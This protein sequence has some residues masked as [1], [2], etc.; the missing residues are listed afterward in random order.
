MKIENSFR[1]LIEVKK[2]EDSRRISLS[3]RI[4]VIHQAEFMP[5]LGFISK[6][7]MG[8]LYFVFDTA[9]FSKE[10][11]ENRNKIRIANGIGWQWLIIPAKGNKSHILNLQDV[12]IA[13]SKWKMKHLKSIQYSYQRAPFF[14]DYFPELESI[15][16]NYAGTSLADYNFELIKFA[17]RKFKINI[18]VY[19]TS[20][21]IRNGYEI[22][23]KATELVISMCKVAGADVCVAGAQG[24][25]YLIRERFE[26]EKITLVFQ[27]FIHPVYPQIHGAFIPNMS[28]ID[29]L[30]NCGE[31]APEI[32]G[33]SDF[34][35]G[36]IGS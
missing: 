20:E 26:Q 33:K 11:F 7:A 31:Q 27:K 4:L 28:F 30:F 1:K 29:L 5:W 16:L 17:F 12:V 13:D 10:Y 2:N 35:S 9:Q 36:D 23:G 32:L 18:P 15:V 22:T 14:S 34:D 21:L 19:R 3:G 6:A 25:D 8:D 24:K